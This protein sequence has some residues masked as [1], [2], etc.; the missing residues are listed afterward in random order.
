M[1]TNRIYGERKATM[2]SEAIRRYGFWFVDALGG[3][4]IRQYV[5]DLEKK[6]QGE[7]DTSSDDL[8]NLLIHA[9]NTTAFYKPFRGFSNITEF[10]IIKK[11]LVKEK[12]AQFIYIR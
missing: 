7:R 10:P 12:Y 8:R 5:S 3:G 2:F 11:S 6:L 4:Q 9:V 1:F